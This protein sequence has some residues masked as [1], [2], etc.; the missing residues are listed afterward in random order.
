M[1]SAFK[2]AIRALTD[3][4]DWGLL[5]AIVPLLLVG[6]VTINSFADTNPLF[7]RQI[8]WILLSIII[9]ITAS[10]VDWRFLRRTGVIMTLFIISVI[11][12]ILLFIF[13]SFAKGAISRFDLG[14]FFFQ[15]SEVRNA[16]HF[17]SLIIVIKYF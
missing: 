12:L 10:L 11:S 9:F 8:V 4:M 1:E 15:P 3:A 14:L 6:L 5:L 2:R 13:G 7:Q 16:T 17:Q